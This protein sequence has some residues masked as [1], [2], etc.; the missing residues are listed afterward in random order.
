MLLKFI[1]NLDFQMHWAK[2][3]SVLAHMVD[4]H[5]SITYLYWTPIFKWYV[6]RCD[7]KNGYKKVTC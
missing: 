3:F 4:V 5:N 1:G 2:V 7:F 6:V